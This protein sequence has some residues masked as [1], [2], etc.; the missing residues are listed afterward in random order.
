M[1][2]QRQVEVGNG[3]IRESIKINFFWKIHMIAN[4]SYDNLKLD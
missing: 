3:W 1:R 2:A 4:T